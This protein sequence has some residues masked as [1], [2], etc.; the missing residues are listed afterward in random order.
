MAKA[1]ISL[2]LFEITSNFVFCSFIL[3]FKLKYSSI[4]CMVVINKSLFS[5]IFPNLSCSSEYFLSKKFVS[6][7]N[8]EFVVALTNG[9]GLVGD[10][11]EILKAQDENGVEDIQGVDSWNR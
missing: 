8:A 10:S 4:N 3:C 2:N 6:F 9:R 1:F 7:F 11:Y 5:P